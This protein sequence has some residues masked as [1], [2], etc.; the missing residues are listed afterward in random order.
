MKVF[1]IGPTVTND[2]LITRNKL[3]GLCK[4][5]GCEAQEMASWKYPWKV[6]DDHV[7]FIYQNFDNSEYITI[8]WRGEHKDENCRTIH[9]NNLPV[10]AD[11]LRDA[12]QWVRNGSKGSL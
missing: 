7:G 6:S 11:E 8:M 3:L 2:E 10:V 4:E 12:V 9:T 1:I 5:L